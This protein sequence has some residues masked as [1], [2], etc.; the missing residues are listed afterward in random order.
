MHIESTA[1][2]DSVLAYQVSCAVGERQV[3]RGFE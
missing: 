1:N 3:N 2:N